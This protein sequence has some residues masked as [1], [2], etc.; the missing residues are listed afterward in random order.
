MSDEHDPIQVLYRRSGKPLA[1]RSETISVVKA[2]HGDET[3]SESSS[4][5]TKKQL[6]RPPLSNVHGGG[7][8]LLS[9]IPASCK[10]PGVVVGIDE[11]TYTD[12]L[13]SQIWIPYIGCYRLS[14]HIRYYVL[15][16]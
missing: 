1:D 5:S 2:L 3:P 10:Q 11:G 16:T 8:L 14:H 4:S 7:P 13:S 9:D 15:C 6:P 12:S